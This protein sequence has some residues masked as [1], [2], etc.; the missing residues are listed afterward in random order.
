MSNSLDRRQFV[1]AVAAGGPVA[2]S[3]VNSWAAEDSPSRRIVV[4]TMGLGGRGTSLSCQFAEQPGVEVAYV[5]DVDKR[6]V[7]NAVRAVGQVAGRE[8]RGVGDFRRILDDPAVDALVIATADHW[9]APA[10]I[11]ACAAGKHVYV[12][13]PCCHNP[14]E[15]ELLVAAARKYKRLVQ[16]GTQRRSWPSHQEAVAKLHDGVIGRVLFSRAMDVSIRSSIGLGKPTPVPDWLDWDL[17]QG[18]APRRPYRDNIVHYNWHYLW[19]WGCGGIGN[20]GIHMMDIC[21]W[22]LGVDFAGQVSSGG[23]NLYFDDD[24]DTP[25]THVVSYNFGDSMLVFESRTWHRRGFEGPQA[26][27]IAFYGDGGSLIIR[28]TAY[29]IYDMLNRKID[30]GSGRAGEVDHIPNF[31]DGIREG[32]PLNAEIEIGHKSTLLCHLGAIAHRT[33]HTLHCDPTTGR[34]VDD[35]EAQALWGREYEPGW[36]PKV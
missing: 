16:H 8:P 30:E 12:E 23:G 15:G 11:L 26:A 35:P 32:T 34:I 17:W 27:N 18:P 5:C 28:G 7:A 10:A 29:T 36:E 13:K 14:R 19:H 24:R 2:A 33:G 20:I 9:H 6:R 3:A 31:L 22:G 1:R 4:G 21:R 25:D